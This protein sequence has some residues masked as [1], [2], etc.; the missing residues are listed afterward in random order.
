MSYYSGHYAEFGINIQA[1]CDSSCRFVYVS[2]SAPGRTS[3]VVALRKISL[4]QI[5]EDLP[6]GKYVIGDNAYVCT[7]HLL[8]PFP[9]EQ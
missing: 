6:L 8:T 9:G 1:A 3:D 2:V 7:E 4:C 5:I